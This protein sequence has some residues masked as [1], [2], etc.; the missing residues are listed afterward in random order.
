MARRAASTSSVSEAE[1]FVVDV[2]PISA[3]GAGRLELAHPLVNGGRGEP[4][5]AGEFGV[6]GAGVLP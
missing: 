2:G 4:D 5:L 1:G 3:D 6:R